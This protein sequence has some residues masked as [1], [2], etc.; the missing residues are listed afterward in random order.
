MPPFL[1]GIYYTLVSLGEAFGVQ[2]SA[3]NVQRSTFGVRRLAAFNESIPAT[4]K[5]RVRRSPAQ[6]FLDSGPK[7]P[8][9]PVRLTVG[10]PE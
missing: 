2:R 9:I 7:K 6:P 1:P 5:W 3:L 8:T 10:T 4:G